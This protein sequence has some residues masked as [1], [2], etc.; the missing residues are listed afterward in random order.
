MEIKR[1]EQSEKLAYRVAVALVGAGVIGVA[2]SDAFAIQAVSICAIMGGW[3]TFDVFH[4]APQR[5]E[6]AAQRE[7]EQKEAI[8]A[9]VREMR[10]S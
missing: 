9:E 1:D 10:I 4:L 3:V 6:I 5:R 7:Q 2:A 8:L